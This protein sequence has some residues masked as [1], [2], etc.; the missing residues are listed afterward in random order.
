M[1]YKQK[2]SPFNHVNS[3]EEED[4]KRGKKLEAEGHKGHAEALYDDAHDSYNWRGGKDGSEPMHAE[5]RYLREGGDVIDETA[6]KSGSFMSRH[7][8]SGLNYGS[9]LHKEEKK[10]K[11]TAEPTTLKNVTITA[12]DPIDDGTKLMKNL[13]IQA[14]K[15]LKAGDI[16]TAQ[17]LKDQ[18]MEIR[19]DVVSMQLKRNDGSYKRN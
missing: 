9:P 4:V 15:S 19:R 11:T 2:S 12:S 17:S 5:S 1:A 13:G 18:Q 16:D 14:R 3:W 6:Q 10:V 8:Q 7:T